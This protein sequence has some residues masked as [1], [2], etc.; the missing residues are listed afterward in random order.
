MARKTKTLSPGLAGTLVALYAKGEEEGRDPPTEF[1][2]FSKGVNRSTKGDFLFDEEASSSVM[3]EYESHGVD[4]SIDYDH[5]AVGN[6][7]ARVVAAGW[8]KLEL[9][10]G[11]LWATD[12]KWTPD[13]AEHLRKG[14]YRY[15]S[16]LFNFDPET[17]RIQKIVNSALTNT[18]ALFQIP[19]LVA[20]SATALEDDMPDDF[21]EKLKKA[22]AEIDK[23][24]AKL[25]EKDEELK[26]LKSKASSV[27]LS[28]TVGLSSSAS[29]DEVRSTVAALVTFRKEVTAIS[30]KDTP[31]AALGALT[32]MKERAAEA[33]ALRRRADEAETAALSAEF[34]KHLDTL[35]TTG[36]DG[37]FLPPAA[38]E[39]A[40]ALAMDLGG[41]KL[42]KAGVEKAKSYV[43]GMLVPGTP[44][45]GTKAKGG[46]VTLS[47]QEVFVARRLGIPE[48]DWQERETKRLSAGA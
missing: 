26:S 1:R 15:F 25:E 24:K 3:A 39:K 16:P 21:E 2:L 41:G 9:R 28:A 11:D 5:A 40:E 4:L 13:G 33:D 18:P 37:K 27:A 44:T 32:A 17:G 38:R 7:G 31:E 45:G 14:E 43:A 10:E 19:A 48:K 47:T 23:L 35:S 30:G 46:T 22:L 36:E 6:S 42:T 12:V 8:F 29:S 20:A 34:G